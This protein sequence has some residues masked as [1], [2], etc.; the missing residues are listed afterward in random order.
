MTRQRLLLAE[1]DEICA[2]LALT[3]L[4]DY[5]VT[6]ATDGM[7]ARE[8]L[9]RE[10]FDALITDISMPGGVDGIQLLDEA[11]RTQPGI[12]CL[13]VSCIT[14][15]RQDEIRERHAAMLQKP[16]TPRLL[17]AAVEGLFSAA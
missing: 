4:A 9:H 12:P 13:V 3:C 14:D 11:S 6:W 10:R 15:V 2:L 5:E 7:E 1:D 17:R 8:L 16:Y